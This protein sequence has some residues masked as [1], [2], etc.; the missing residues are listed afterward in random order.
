MERSTTGNDEK[1]VVILEY[2]RT[3]ERSLSLPGHR[4]YLILNLHRSFLHSFVP[5]QSD[6]QEPVVSIASLKTGADSTP[7][8]A[9]AICVVEAAPREHVVSKRFGGSI[10]KV[11]Y[12]AD[13]GNCSCAHFPLVD[14]SSGTSTR[15]IMVCISSRDAIDDPRRPGMTINL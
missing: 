11:L 5:P 2:N 1:E 4:R 9:A 14:Q 7:R 15:R 13:L 6:S 10:T 3:V 12:I 8:A